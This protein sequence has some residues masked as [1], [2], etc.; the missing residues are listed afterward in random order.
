MNTI[1][2]AVI[3]YYNDLKLNNESLIPLLKKLREIPEDMYIKNNENYIKDVF[4]VQ[5]RIYYH[6]TGYIGI[7]ST[8]SNRKDRMEVCQNLY[9]IAKTYHTSIGAV[10]SKT[11]TELTGSE[12]NY[13][14]GDKECTANNTCLINRNISDI[15]DR[16]RI[17][18]DADECLFYY[19]FR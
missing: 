6:N 8:I 9:S 1:I 10:L 7:L 4:G 18:E 17:C 16:C 15:I 3:R 14:F 11:Q 19:I 5:Y 12:S 13:V 2:N